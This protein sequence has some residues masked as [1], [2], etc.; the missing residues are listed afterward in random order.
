LAVKKLLW[1]RWVGLEN[2][3]LSFAWSKKRENFGSGK[4]RKENFDEACD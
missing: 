3:L 1:L 2:R 4:S